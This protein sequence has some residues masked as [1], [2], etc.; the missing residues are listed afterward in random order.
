M[1]YLDEIAT[2]IR[3]VVPT[4][5]LPDAETSNL[6]RLYA[7]LLLVKG[8]AVTREDVHNVWVAWMEGNG[9]V[10]ESMV[11]YDELPPSTKDEDSV[12]VAAIRHIARQRAIG[13]DP[14]S[15]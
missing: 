5:A 10:H 14:Q 2:D 8:E 7:V 6:F 15:S 11:P 9:D 3:K 13:A 1:T 12:F 4:D